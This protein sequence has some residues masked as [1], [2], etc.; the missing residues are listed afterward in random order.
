MTDRSEERMDDDG[1]DELDR[2]LFALPLAE[3]PAGLRAAIL[4]ATVYAQPVAS[5]AFGRTETIVIGVVLALAAWLLI[6]CVA[7]RALAAGLDALVLDVVRGLA[8]TRT[9]LWLGFGTATAVAFTKGRVPGL[10]AS[11][12]SPFAGNRPS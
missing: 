11:G 8:D 3:P 6:A 1:T 4:R 7:D 5:A 12:R 2:A 10:G 9:I